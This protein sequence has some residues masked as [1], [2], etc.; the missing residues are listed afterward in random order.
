MLSEGLWRA[1]SGCEQSEAL[2]GVFQQWQ[3]WV[4]TA[5]DF[6]KCSMQTL[7]CCCQMY[8]VNGGDHVE[9]LCFVAENLLYH[10]VLLCTLHL[11]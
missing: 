11:L 1:E 3:Q 4:T 2:G 5:D 8:I 6:Y 9:K 10:T 7:V